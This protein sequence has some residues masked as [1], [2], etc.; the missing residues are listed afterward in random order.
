[1]T[2]LPFCVDAFL[3]QPMGEPV[4]AVHPHANIERKV[5]TDAQPHPTTSRVVDIEII[6]MDVPPLHR[7]AVGLGQEDR[8][9]FRFAAFQNDGD[10]RL[11]LQLL[12][13][14][15]DPIFATAVLA[16]FDDG[17]SSLQRMVDDPVP[18]VVGNAGTVGAVGIFR[19]PMGSQK[20]DDGATTFGMIKHWQHALKDDP[21]KARIAEANGLGV[22][23]YEAVHG[24]P[25]WGGLT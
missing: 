2:R 19:L 15:L 5:R 25:P 24:G 6:M 16:R 21:I 7:Q 9:P 1:M 18:V 14:G 23:T 8:D 10:P 3:L 12:V 17:D 13:V 20:P 22:M 11:A 4:M